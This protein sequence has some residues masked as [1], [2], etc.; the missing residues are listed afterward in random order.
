[1]PGRNHP[2]QY[3]VADDVAVSECCQ[4]VAANQGHH[5]PGDRAVQSFQLFAERARRGKGTGNIEQAEEG[6]GISAKPFEPEAQSNLRD[7]EAVKGQM[8]GA[9]RKV[10]PWVPRTV[11]D[12]A[13]CS[14][15][16]GQAGNDD[17]GQ[18]HTKRNVDARQPAQPEVAGEVG[19]GH[20]RSEQ[21]ENQKGCEPVES[22]GHCVISV[23]GWAIGHAPPA[24]IDEILAELQRELDALLP[25]WLTGLYLVGSLALNDY[26]PGRSDIDFVAVTSGQDGYPA[27]A[28]VHAGLARR[29]RHVHCDGI[30]VTRDELARPAGGRGPAAREGRVIISSADERHPVTWLTLADHGLALRGPAPGRDWIAVD[31]AAALVY[32]RSNLETYWRRW[33]DDRRLPVTRHGLSLLGGK[34]V[35]WGVLGVARLHAAIHEGR[36]LSKSGAGLHALS[37]LPGHAAIIH[38]ALGLRRDPG[39]RSAYRSRLQR[40]RD[41]IAFMDAVIGPMP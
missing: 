22:D 15:S 35:T 34:A 28:E 25:G 12:A 38:E 30:Y 13:T 29:H 20:G 18:R 26:Q 3:A 24:E 11:V 7:Q 5:R 40:R 19:P 37:A 32:S 33:I 6:K 10:R 1:M 14:Q 4:R 16:P 8:H 36:V 27:L 21:R 41:T 23:M 31:P 17:A 9:R 39:S 2:P